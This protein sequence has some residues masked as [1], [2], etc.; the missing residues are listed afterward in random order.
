LFEHFKQVLAVS[1]LLGARP[2]IP[3]VPAC[4][5]GMRESLPKGE[6]PVLPYRSSVNFGRPA[7]A[8]DTDTGRIMRQINE[9]FE[10]LRIRV[11]SDPPGGNE[12]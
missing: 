3:Y 5:T 1:A 4:L 6:I 2:R 8:A 10:A 11:Q 7:R 9:D 12:D